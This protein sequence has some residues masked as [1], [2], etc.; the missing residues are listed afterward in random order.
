M[1][2]LLSA[3]TGVEGLEHEQLALALV[4]GDRGIQKFLD[5][6][7]ALVGLR[8]LHEPVHDG[9]PAIVLN[10]AFDDMDCVYGWSLADSNFQCGDNLSM[11]H[12]IY[13][14]EIRHAML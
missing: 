14:L 12:S 13:L 1:P 3:A 8:H 10:E 7:K 11:N 2:G 4:D 5:I 6:V 9:V